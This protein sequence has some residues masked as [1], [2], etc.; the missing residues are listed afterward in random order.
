MTHRRK[1]ALN[2]SWKQTF[3][4]S[5]FGTVIALGV[6]N[7]LFTMTVNANNT[8]ISPTA[9]GVS[10]QFVET[11]SEVDHVST[12]GAS[13]TPTPTPENFDVI[14]K[15]KNIWGKDANIGLAI[16][17]CESHLNKNAYHINNDGTIDFSVF[18]INTVH[19]AILDPQEN[20]KYAYNLYLQQGTT[21][22][23]S[24]KKCWEAKL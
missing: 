5:F 7:S 19:T 2:L 10:N 18:Q 24:S 11:I 16:A 13:I 23:N 9:S 17:S 20:I 14:T 12:A 4:L 6:L 22:W 8:I 21:P 15:I 1:N 3:G